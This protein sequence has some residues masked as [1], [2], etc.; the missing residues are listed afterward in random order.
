MRASADEPLS[1][2]CS[3]LRYMAPEMFPQWHMHVLKTGG[4]VLYDKKVDV[5]A[6]GLVAYQMLYGKLPF[7][8]GDDPAEDEDDTIDRIVHESVEPLTFPDA[9]ADA[10][11]PGGVSEGAR[12]FCAAARARRRVAA[13]RCR[14]APRPVDACGSGRR[15]GQRGI[16]RVR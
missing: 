15:G 4:D 16:R 13:G 3:T 5:W 10:D 7:G 8:L 2:G 6:L 14:G 9:D 12:A 11:A 1:D